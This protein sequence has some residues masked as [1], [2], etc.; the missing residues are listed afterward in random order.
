MTIHGKEISF[1]GVIALALSKAFKD[2]RE[3]FGRFV[4]LKIEDAGFAVVAIDHAGVRRLARFKRACEAVQG[5]KRAF[6]LS[7]LLIAARTLIEM[8]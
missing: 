8:S 3:P 6:L 2:G 1:A 5:K 7:R 4:P